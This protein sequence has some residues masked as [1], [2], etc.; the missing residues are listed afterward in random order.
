MGLENVNLPKGRPN[1]LKGRG[2]LNND[3]SW[4]GNCFLVILTIIGINYDKN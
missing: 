2:F 4:I 1:S 3:N